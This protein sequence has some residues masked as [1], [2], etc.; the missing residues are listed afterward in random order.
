LAA[1]GLKFLPAEAALDLPP[2]FQE[3]PTPQAGK[4]AAPNQQSAANP[5]N[6]TGQSGQTMSP[7]D[8]MALQMMMGQTGM[9]G[10]NGMNMMPWMMPGAMGTNGNSSTMDPNMMSTMMMNQMMQNMNLGG[11]SEENH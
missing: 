9:G 2:R 8:W 10:S 4:V 11:S 3:T 1:D 6:M 7:Q 5:G